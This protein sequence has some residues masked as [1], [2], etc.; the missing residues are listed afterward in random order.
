MD[1]TERQGARERLVIEAQ[2]VAVRADGTLDLG[3]ALGDARFF[4]G[5]DAVEEASP[6]EVNIRWIAG[7][8]DAQRQRL[9]RR[10]GL[11]NGTRRS[12]QTW[13]Y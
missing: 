8:E 11:F 6:L 3:G 4:T 7:L 12:A 9:E 5:L 1:V 13:Q 2:P 10:F